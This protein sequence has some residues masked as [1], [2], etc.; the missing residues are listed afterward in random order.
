MAYALIDPN[1]NEG[2]LVVFA[3][4]AA[5]KEACIERAETCDDVSLYSG[6]S[7]FPLPDGTRGSIKSLES[8][9]F[10]IAKIEIK[11]LT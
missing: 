5:N 3:T 9:G 11:I 10:R 7:K 4:V 2:D 8:H 6:G 1:W